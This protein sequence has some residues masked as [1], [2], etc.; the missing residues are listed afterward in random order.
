MKTRWFAAISVWAFVAWQCSAASAPVLSSLHSFG[1]QG[2]A[3]NPYAEVIEGSDG[4]LYG[5]TALGGSGGKGTVFRVNKDGSGYQ[6][7]KSFGALTNDGL[8][9]MAAV[10][11][12]SDGK[13]YGTAQEGGDFGFGTI[14]S[15]SKD[16]SNFTVLRSFSQA[17]GGYPEARLLEASDGLL[18]GTASGGGTN[19]NGAIF[20]ISKDGFT[21]STLI[22][23]SG[24]NGA[25]PEGGLIEASD[26]M[27]YG[28]TYSGGA[29]NVGTVFR[30]NKDG[31]AFEVLKHLSIP[32]GSL[33]LQTNGCAP[34][35][36]LVEGTNGMIYGTT[37]AG[38]TNAGGTIFRLNKDG[39]SFQILRSFATATGRAPLGELIR[40]SNGLLFGTTSDGGS[41]NGG[42]VFQI[43]HDGSGYTIL[44]NL[45]IPRTP[46]A[47]LLE[48]SDGYLY[49]T[50]SSG[51]D[52]G[53]GA[54]FKVQK[55][56]G[57]FAVIKSF[58]IG[59]GDGLLSDAG[60]TIA[61]DGALYGTTR[62][63][64][65]KNAGTIYSIH[66]DGSG[67]RQ[68][69][70]LD[71]STASGPVASVVEGTN[72]LLY[73]NSRVGGAVNSGTIFSVQKDGNNFVSRY[74]PPNPNLGQ[75]P[76][77]TLLQVSNGMFFGTTVLGGS[78]GQGIAFTILSDGSGYQV[79]QMFSNGIGTPGGNPIEKLIQASDTSVYGT[80]Y[81]GGASNNGVIFKFSQNGSGY[82]I[83]KSF[84][85]ATNEGS[86]PMAPVTE[87]T[88]GM[89]YGSTYAG[90]AN[91]AG[92]VFRINKNGTGFQV[93]RKFVG[94]G[95]DGR[96]PSGKLVEGIDGAIYGATERGGT[97]DCGTLFKINKIGTGYTVLANFGGSLGKYPHGGLQAG[98][99]GALY[100]TTEQGGDSDFGAIFRF[101]APGEEFTDIHVLGGTA[102]LTCVGIPGTNY[103]ILRA[104]DLGPAAVWASIYSTN[105]PAGGRFTVLDPNLL[106]GRAFYRLSR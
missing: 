105:A 31:S 41:F 20:R 99:D 10:I 60:M 22:T 40:A 51:G 42:T 67:Y 92:I 75:E 33:S 59:A 91:N 46:A 102:V 28:T 25:N 93:L 80:T 47:G 38:G 71:G 15:L 17:E 3:A 100:G 30:L 69:I 101:G 81:S 53:A 1:F 16:G 39:S 65:S 104:A 32:S 8:T 62:A 55:S 26:Q 50:S 13:L 96:H 74:S 35:G 45:N 70:G 14:F 21:Y 2:S 49:G 58:Q 57:P 98:P 89:L 82:S 24:T 48:A 94:V 95:T 37:S 34:Y 29:S 4:A 6:L 5:T 68:V 19:D 61:S 43:A 88:D 7:L 23:F 72:G 27:L 9:P 54:V 83:V 90:G 12:A 76:R 84:G 36:R 87:A 73:G 103:T 79:L 77:G 86:N 64:G 52:S 66:P 78:S 85:V 56:G 97:N 11:E 18:Y 44:T 63:G 106:P